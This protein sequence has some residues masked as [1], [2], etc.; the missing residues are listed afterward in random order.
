MTQRRREKVD[1]WLN[2]D[3]PLGL[4]STSAVGRVRWLFSAAKAGHGGTLDPLASGVLPIAL[5]EAT[6]TVP[7]VMDGRKVYRFTIAFGQATAT[8]DREG[9]I[10]GESAVRPSD[11]DLARSLEAFTGEIE[12]RPPAFS[13]LKIDGARA[14][15]L[16]R[17]GEAVELAPRRVRVDRLVV[18]A[19]PSADLAELE[20]ECGKGTYV[21]SLARDI[22]RTVGTVGHVAALSRTVCGPF[23]IEDAIS[24]ATLEAAA[25]SLPKEGSFG[26]KPALLGHL[27]P[28]VTALDDIPALALT[29]RQAQRLSAGV[30]VPMTEIAGAGAPPIGTMSPAEGSAE[31][32]RIVRAM[33]GARL[34]AIARID[35]D[36]LRP[37][38]V[39]NL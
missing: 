6:K 20:V 1:G 17:G 38:R 7:W 30:A 29:D 15:D 25:N 33:A 3:K 23:R 13:A 36:L 22:A 2:L 14:Y 34:V 5:G 8:D 37:V 11:R 31:P 28:V 16:A 18:L 10:V 39:L 12:Q 9:A 24:M 32:A 4:G 21:R 19:R 27:W 26:H 35:G